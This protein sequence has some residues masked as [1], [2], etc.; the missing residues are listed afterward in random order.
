MEFL[1][2]AVAPDLDP[3]NLP[4]DVVE[5]RSRLRREGDGVFLE[6]PKLLSSYEFSRDPF[7]LSG[8]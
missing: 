5:S 1:I 8:F 6:E 4:G 2:G 3:Y 7:F